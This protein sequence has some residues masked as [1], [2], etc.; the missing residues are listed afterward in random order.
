MDNFTDLPDEV[1][2]FLDSHYVIDRESK[3]IDGHEYMFIMRS[4]WEDEG[5]YQYETIYFQQDDDLKYL[6]CQ[7]SA[8]YFSDYHYS[9]ET[10]GDT[11]WEALY[12]DYIIKKGLVVKLIEQILDENSNFIHTLKFVVD[13]RLKIL[14]IDTED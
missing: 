3:T 14:G 12:A 7:R 9:Y 10:V 5:K 2:E 6:V 8:S 11:T 4:D 1:I 13:L